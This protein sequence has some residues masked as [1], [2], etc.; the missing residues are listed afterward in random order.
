MMCPDCG[1]ELKDF[2]GHFRCINLACDNIEMF[3]G[4]CD[5]KEIEER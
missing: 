5:D 1:T 2:E 4:D 3:E